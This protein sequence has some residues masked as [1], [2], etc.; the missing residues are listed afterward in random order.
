MAL[1]AADGPPLEESKMAYLFALISAAAFIY[2]ARVALGM[3]RDRAAARARI[4]R[5]VRPVHGGSVIKAAPARA[6]NRPGEN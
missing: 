3:V 5:A 4:A 1:R 6:F 2:A